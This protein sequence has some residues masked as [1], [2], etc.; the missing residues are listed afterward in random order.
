MET[1]TGGARRRSGGGIED[2]RG[3]RIRKGNKRM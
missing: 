3:R 2:K 1:A